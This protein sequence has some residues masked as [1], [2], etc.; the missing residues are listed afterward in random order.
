MDSLKLS[1]NFLLRVQYLWDFLCCRWWL[2]YRW[3][4][5]KMEN[6]QHEKTRSPLEEKVTNVKDY[7]SWYAK[8]RMVDMNE[9]VHQCRVHKVGKDK[10]L[11]KMR[12][13]FKI[14]HTITNN[15]VEGGLN[16]RYFH[17]MIAKDARNLALFTLN[18]L[19]DLT[20]EYQHII[21]KNSSIILWWRVFYLLTFKTLQSWNKI[22]RLWL[23]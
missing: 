12:L 10:V 14:V 11:L 9:K 4:L 1:K 6:I 21:I 18:Q 8:K 15:D 2:C 16:P 20:L 17:K 22:N 23:I 7:D 19:K 5:P 13:C 3:E